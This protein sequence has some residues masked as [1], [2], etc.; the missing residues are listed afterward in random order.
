MKK[1][2]KYAMMGL[3]LSLGFVAC[4]VET[5]EE[6][7]GTNVQNLA[8]HWMVTVDIVDEAGNTLYSDPYGLGEIAVYTYNT[9]ANDADSIWITDNNNFW[10]FMMKIP[11]NNSALTFSCPEKDYDAA[12]TG[13]AIITNGKVLLGAAKNLH[14]MPN[15]SI[16]F[17]IS[18]NDDEPAYGYIYRM[19]GQKYTG[20]YE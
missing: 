11:A 16:V 20:F 9:A 13:K 10:Q 2:L 7:G 12:G 6:A 4:D 3:C 15:D 14:G 8:G 1:F 5:D 17:D 18:F 19:S